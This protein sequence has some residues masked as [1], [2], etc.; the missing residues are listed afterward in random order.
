MALARPPP[1]AEVVSHGSHALT[2]SKAAAI[3]IS[4]PGRSLFMVAN[5]NFRIALTPK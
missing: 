1:P 2:T 5:P 4:Q 3:V